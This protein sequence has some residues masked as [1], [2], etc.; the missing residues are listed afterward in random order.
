MSEVTESAPDGDSSTITSLAV[1][2]SVGMMAVVIVASVTVV[3]VIVLAVK[4]QKSKLSSRGNLHS[5]FIL[6]A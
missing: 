3:L 1:G 2:M 6:I 5:V 4:L